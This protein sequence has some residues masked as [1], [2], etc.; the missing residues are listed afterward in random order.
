MAKKTTKPNR[1]PTIKQKLAFD[2]TME[3]GGNKSKA[4]REVGYSEAT[5]NRP[6]NLTESDGWQTLMEQHIPDSKLLRVVDEG[7]E[8]M[9]GDEPDHAIRHKFADTG[10]KLKGSYAPE[11]KQ[12]VH[13]NI[14]VDLKAKEISDKYE[15]EIKK[16]LLE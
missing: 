14:N 3:N 11:K 12:T 10:F 2:K 15:E 9:K 1:K 6:K 7:L 4:M 8:A 5:I 16:T 13:A